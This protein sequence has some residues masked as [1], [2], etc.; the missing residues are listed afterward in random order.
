MAGPSSSTP[1]SEGH[2]ELGRE[3]HLWAT[4]L[5][6]WEPQAGESSMLNEKPEEEMQFTLL[7]VEE[8]TPQTHRVTIPPQHPDSREP[9]QRLWC[10]VYCDPL[11][12]EVPVC[13]MYEDFFNC[14]PFL[15]QTTCALITGQEIYC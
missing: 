5:K 3:A 15:Y 13:E 11:W 7:P 6:S 9:N 12:G 8:D 14:H 4:E 2:D 1:L 10:P